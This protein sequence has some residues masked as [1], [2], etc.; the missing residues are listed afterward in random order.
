MIPRP[1]LAFAALASLV[2]V[3]VVRADY[4]LVSHRYLADPATMVHEGRVYVYCSNDDDNPVEGGYQMKSLVCVSSSDMKNWTDH[5]E[6]IR[7]PRDAAWASNSWA[8]DTIER[9]GKFY[10]YFP[11]GASNIGVAVSDSPTGPFVDPLGVPL[12]TAATPGVLPATNIWIF[13]PGVFIDDDGQAY[14]Y[15]GGNGE[16]NL[17]IIRLNEDMISVSGSAIAVTVPNFF[18]AAWMHKRDNIYYLSYSTVPAAGLRIDYLTG[19][20]PIG[21]FTYGGIV[22]GQPPVNNNNNHAAIF[23]LNGAWYEVYHNRAVA[24]AAQIPTTYRRNIAVESLTYAP[25]GLINQ[26]TYTTNGVVQQRALN[27]YQRV[28]AETTAGQSG[29]E[30]EVCSE[31]GMNVTALESADWIRVRGVDFGSGGADRVNI[32]AAS[33]SGGGTLTL[34]LGSATGPAIA[35][36]PIAATGGAQ[37]WTTLSADVSGATGTHDLYLTVSGNGTSLFNLNWWQFAPATSPVITSQ[38]RSLAVGSGERASLWV[39]NETGA[40]VTYQWF[41][42]DVAI[43]GATSSRLDFSAVGNAQTGSYHTTLTNSA[44][45]TTSE[46][47]TITLSPGTAAQLSNLSVRAPLALNEQLVAGFVLT[48]S[49]PRELLIRGVGPTLKSFDITDAMDDPK[50]TIFQGLNIQALSDD[51]HE[52]LNNADIIAAAQTRGAFTLLADSADAAVFAP[53]SLAPHTAQ[54]VSADG[55][56]SGVVL[57]ELY[58]GDSTTSRLTNLSARGKTTSGTGILTPGFSIAGERAMT[59][60]IR[61]VGETLGK[62]RVQNRIDNPTLSLFQGSQII[63]RNDDWSDA[64]NASAI[65]AAAATVGAFALSEGSLDAAMLVTLM[66]GSYTVQAVGIGRTTGDVLVEVYEVP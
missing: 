56:G 43:D 9:N 37:T 57:C 3:P 44:G 53:F 2:A 14:L 61:A 22:A 32:R 34:R 58:A 21:P 62:F 6:V 7:V 50:L 39:Q 40:P 41:H 64:P 60:L 8:P 1:V 42:D 17:R 16:S 45:T 29:I 52:E 46:P 63:L 4:P 59:V 10:L 30:T 36:L 12:I 38:P 31:G 28:E 11:N 13:D 54:V 23:Q 66:P 51:W 25:N 20:S 49:Q 33:A 55:T 35:T 65:S 15:F 47:A 5:G 19:D 18:E 48:G 26:V 24:T 27:P